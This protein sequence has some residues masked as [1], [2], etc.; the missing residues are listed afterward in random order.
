MRPQVEDEM[1]KAKSVASDVGDKAKN[2][3][4]QSV[5]AASKLGSEASKATDDLMQK[6]RD[7][8][9]NAQAKLSDSYEMARDEFKKAEGEL[10]GM[11]KKN[12]II[13]IAAAAGIG[14][15]V[16]RYLTSRSSNQA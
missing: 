2:L 14:W 7:T 15:A 11:I 1:N 4:A 5:E 16:G 12:P 6:A 13:A 8:F 9:G 3:K 10:E